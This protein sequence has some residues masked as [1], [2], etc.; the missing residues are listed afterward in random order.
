MSNPVLGVAKVDLSCQPYPFL[1]C[2]DGFF[3]CAYLANNLILIRYSIFSIWAKLFLVS[4][5]FVLWN[6]HHL[7]RSRPSCR[8]VEAR[9]WIKFAL[10]TSFKIYCLWTVN[11][12]GPRISSFF[13]YLHYSYLFHPPPLL[14]LGPWL[15]ALLLQLLGGFKNSFQ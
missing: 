10:Y 8:S 7:D 3:L 12:I 2:S 1:L 14:R 13:L 11:G 5:S 4:S 6:L 9:Y 15:I